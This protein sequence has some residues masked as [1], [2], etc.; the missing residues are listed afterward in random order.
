MVTELEANTAEVARQD[1]Q[2]KSGADGLQAGTDEDAR[3]AL[4]GQ[5]HTVVHNADDG[6]TLNTE[7]T[8]IG[9]L[10]MEHYTGLNYMADEQ[11]L[12]MD[13]LVS[14]YFA[15]GDIFSVGGQIPPTTF[16]DASSLSPYLDMMWLVE[17]S[18][19]TGEKF[20]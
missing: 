1:T 9:G 14:D 10:S 8:T 4:A 2:Y 5:S 6:T 13:D 7:T 16:E 12:V 19:K 15:S 18:K 11:P 20:F 3:E 17:A